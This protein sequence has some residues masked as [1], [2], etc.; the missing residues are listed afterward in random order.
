MK[1]GAQLNA[2]TG[3]WMTQV[4]F[5]PPLIALG[6]KKDAGSL[7]MIKATNAF[8]VNF[9]AK[10][11]KALA[12]HFIKP[13]SKVGDKLSTIRHRIG[14]TGAP[15]L[16][17]GAGYLECEVREIA[18]ADGDHAVVIA[19]VVEAA[20]LRDEPP[21]TILDTGWHYGG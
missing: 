2:F 7:E 3:S 11:Q 17:E 12:E 5:T 14:K 20:I 16:E 21:L 13:A 9:L 4:S 10:D 6:V 18:G 15:I 8:T 19:E 1:H